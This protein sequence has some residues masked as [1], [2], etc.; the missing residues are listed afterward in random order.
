M[1]GRDERGGGLT[2][3]QRRPHLSHYYRHRA[4]HITPG[5]YEWRIRLRRPGIG[6]PNNTLT[7][8]RATTTVS[9]T[10]EGSVLSGSISLQRPAPDA[11]HS[12]PIGVADR[13]TLDVKRNKHWYR[14][15][16]MRVEGEPETD[17]GT[18]TI[19]ATLG[20]D[21]GALEMGERDWEF[22][23]NDA[24]PHG[25]RA[26]EVAK[27]VCQKE[28][29]PVG[30][31]AHGTEDLGK[32]KL[33]DAPGLAVLKEA[34]GRERDATGVRYLIRFRDG[35]LDI[36][37]MRR[38]KI[39]YEIKKVAQDA[40]TSGA[41]PGT[42]PV[43]CIEGHARVHD[44]KVTVKVVAHRAAARFG[45]ITKEEHYGRMGSRDAVRRK[46]HRQLAHELDPK[47]TATFTIP[48][49]PF[50]ERGDTIRWRTK[51]PGWHGEDEL[52]ANRQ[53]CFVT[54]VTHTV[55]PEAQTTNL[56]VNQK[57][58]MVAQL[59]EIDQAKKDDKDK[60]RNHGNGNGSGSGGTPAS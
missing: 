42:R 39:L 25:W 28:S 54:E 47:R 45:Q 5:E 35:K 7:L 21:L 17:T 32:L 23:K 6:K 15:W 11:E 36:T 41:S 57:D 53:F 43:T 9:W 27:R 16:T 29:V 26:H 52:S 13:V 10:D 18:G 3:R 48:C 46:I 56:T 14:L 12:I 40:F 4:G 51:E 60:G 24:H 30:K 44:K 19:T 2:A 58:P 34:Y 49:I 20:D 37:P 22:K 59:R 1:S 50:I 31:L 55:A 8:R 38:N 33:D